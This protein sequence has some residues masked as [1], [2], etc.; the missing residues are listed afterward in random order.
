MVPVT[1][2]CCMYRAVYC[3]YSIPVTRVTMKQLQRGYES[4]AEAE[5]RES[6]RESDVLP[7][8]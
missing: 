3:L 7:N 4:E 6:M 1:I 8:A 2:A 5:R